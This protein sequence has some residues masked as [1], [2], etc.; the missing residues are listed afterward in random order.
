MKYKTLTINTAVPSPPRA[1]VLIIYTGGTFGMIHDATGTL[2]PF[3]FSLILDHLPT[4]RNLFLEITVIEFEHPIDSS[5]IDPSHWL[6]IGQI[7]QEHYH[8]QDGFVVLHGTDTMAYTASAL[9]YMLQHLAKPV[10]FTGAQLPISE[11]RSDARENLITALEIA[12]TREEGKALV[13]EVCIYFDSELLRGNR[14]KKAESMHF[15]AFRSE[16]YPAL[17]NAGVKI[18]YNRS[19]V[20]SASTGTLSLLTRF[21]DHVSILKLFPGI[22]QASVDAILQTPGLKALI[23]E[24]FGSGNAPTA[25]W[26]LGRLKKA[27]DNGLIVLNISQCPGGMVMQGKYETSRSLLELGVISGGDMT[28]EAAVTKVMV[29]LG[30]YSAEETKQRLSISLAGELTAG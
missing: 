24:T 18:D 26:F 3:D 20:R 13:P 14:A 5:N 10:V 23:L 1:R 7:I 6:A 28:L 4:L 2:L 8:Q 25:A 9:S 11:P 27:I 12:S 22:S 16:N 21:D 19:V 29:L 30:N 15:D 17:A